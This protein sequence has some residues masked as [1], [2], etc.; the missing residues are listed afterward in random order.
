MKQRN[1]LIVFLVFLSLFVSG[2]VA[3]AQ[4]FAGWWDIEPA[5][6]FRNIVRFDQD[7]TLFD[8]LS[9]VDALTVADL[10][11]S[12]DVTVTDDL[13]VSDSISTTNLLFSERSALTIGESARLPQ[14]GVISG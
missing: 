8:D 13:V 1:S 11:A 14:P 5:T 10:S 3:L 12:D 7:V 6:R 4:G 9:V 2:G